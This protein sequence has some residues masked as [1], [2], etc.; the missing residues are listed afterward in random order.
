MAIMVEDDPRVQMSNEDRAKKRQTIQTLVTLTK[1]AEEP[2]RKAAGMT[3][4]MT[5]LLAS[6][7]CQTRRR[8]PRRCVRRWTTST[9]A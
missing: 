4:A 8:F 9:R 6:G 2:R 3:T 5:N 1:E 7:S